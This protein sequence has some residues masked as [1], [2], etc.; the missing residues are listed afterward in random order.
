MIRCARGDPNQDV[1]MVY[2]KI[3]THNFVIDQSKGLSYECQDMIKRLLEYDPKRRITSA[4]IFDHPWVKKFEAN[5]GSM[6]MPLGRP[7]Y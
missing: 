1:N 7:R 4:Q 2:Y 6:N 3:K 5:M